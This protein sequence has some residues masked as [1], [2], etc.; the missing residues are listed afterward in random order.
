MGAVNGLAPAVGMARACAALRVNRSGVYRQDARRRHLATAPVPT[1]PRPPAPLAFT[2]SERQALTAILCSERFAD[3]APPTIYATLLDEGTYVGSVRTM[4]RRLA[5]DSQTRE[6][7]N[8]RV[9]PAYTKPEL[10][11]VQPN[12]V[13]SWDITKRTPRQRSPP[14]WG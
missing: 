3:C 10:L 6:R 4:Y 5:A 11:A 2:D 9:H 8:Q 14:V 1:V 13:W 12:E 7:R